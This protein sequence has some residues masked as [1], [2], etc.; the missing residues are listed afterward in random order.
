MIID[1]ISNILSSEDTNENTTLVNKKL[2]GISRDPGS[3]TTCQKSFLCVASSHQGKSAKEIFNPFDN[4]LTINQK[5]VKIIREI[6]EY[7]D[8][9]TTIALGLPSNQ[10]HLKDEG[11][12]IDHVHPLCFIWA[13]LTQPELKKKLIHF[14]D[15][16]AFS[17]KWNGFL[18]YSL[19]HDKGF[20]KNME[21]YYNHRHPEDYRQ[22]FLD[23]YKTLRLKEEVM[24]PFAIMK[25]WRGFASALLDQHSYY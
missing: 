5:E 11:K 16:S 12:K 19:F 3:L 8:S 1:S 17:L 25:N 14:R 7:L 9:K 23:F 4:A 2:G 13:I 10:K 21:K 22:E 24:Q 15:N 18:G 20:G 6:I